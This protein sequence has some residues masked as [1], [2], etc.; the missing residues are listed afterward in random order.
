MTLALADAGMRPEEIDYL[1][2]HGSATPLNDKTE[3]IAIKKVFGSHARVMAISGTKGHHGHALG[4]TGAMEA[5]ACALAM[6]HQFVP[7]TVNLENPDPEC[8]L[9]Y[10][11]GVGRERTI[12]TVLSNSFGFGGINSCVVTA[13]S[14][15]VRS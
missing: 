12:A 3:T 1:N 10:T 14:R 11:P 13:E 2:A 5:V 6:E 8:D 7:P 9:D 15:I 4:A